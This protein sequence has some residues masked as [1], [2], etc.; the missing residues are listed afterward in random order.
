MDKDKDNRHIDLPPDSAELRAFLRAGAGG[1]IE[2]ENV[3][4]YAVVLLGNPP[5]DVLLC[6]HFHSEPDEGEQM[7]LAFQ[8]EQARALHKLL[9]KQLDLL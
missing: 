5:T 3:W 6:V 1:E 7:T 2:V 9:G 8:I 4:R